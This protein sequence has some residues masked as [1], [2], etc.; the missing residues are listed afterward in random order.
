MLI[1]LKSLKC[2]ASLVMFNSFKVFN[3]LI[4]YNKLRILIALK[5]KNAIKL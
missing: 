4:N 2:Y 5:C 1:F 3:I